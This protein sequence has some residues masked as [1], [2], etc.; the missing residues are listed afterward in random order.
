M[1]KGLWSEREEK[2]YLMICCNA[3]DKPKLLSLREHGE[4]GEGLRAACL[5][6]LPSFLAAVTCG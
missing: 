3:R 6:H 4:K 2:L 1:S 5:L